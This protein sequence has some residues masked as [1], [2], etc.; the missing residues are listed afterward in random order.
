MV[1]LQL[2]VLVVARREPPTLPSP[3]PPP[4]PSPP[5]LL[6]SQSSPQPI[7]GR[8][9]FLPVL[10]VHAINHHLPRLANSDFRDLV[11][12]SPVLP[13]PPPPTSLVLLNPKTTIDGAESYSIWKA[14]VLGEVGGAEGQY[15]H[16]QRC[17]NVSIRT[18]VI[19]EEISGLCAIFFG[20]WVVNRWFWP[21]RSLF[22]PQKMLSQGCHTA[23]RLF[24]WGRTIS[25]TKRTINTIYE[26]ACK[27]NNH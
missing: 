7:P 6:R 25:M 12:I 26:D 21:S 5:S 15:K 14:N 2:N 19:S 4:P 24:V 16:D 13:T 20:S 11:G 23:I 22:N 3:P 27:N 18:S 17:R 1:F 9:F 10:R 8:P